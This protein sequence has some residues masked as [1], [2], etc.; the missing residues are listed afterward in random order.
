MCLFNHAM[1]KTT[2][3]IIKLWCIIEIISWKVTKPHLR[4]YTYVRSG[5]GKSFIVRIILE[6]GTKTRLDLG[7]EIQES[8]IFIVTL[9]S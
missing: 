6:E 2:F 1:H 4:K 5:S 9:L 7:R 8:P 3:Y